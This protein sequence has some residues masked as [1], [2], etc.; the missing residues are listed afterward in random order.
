MENNLILF[1]D[2]I[3]ELEIIRRYNQFYVVTLN[4]RV[5]IT[6]SKLRSISVFSY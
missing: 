6:N 2:F 1:F 5:N 3:Y 4:N